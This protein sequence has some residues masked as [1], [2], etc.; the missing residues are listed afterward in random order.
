MFL[1]LSN[2][3]GTTPRCVFS[4]S[5]SLPRHPDLLLDLPRRDAAVCPEAAQTESNA[6]SSARH[7]F[8]PPDPR[9]GFIR[10]SAVERLAGVAAPTQKQRRGLRHRCRPLVPAHLPPNKPS[11]RGRCRQNTK[12]ING[13][14]PKERGFNLS[15]AQGH[16]LKRSPT[17]CDKRD[18]RRRF[19]APRPTE[20]DK[21]QG[22][23]GCSQLRTETQSLFRSLLHV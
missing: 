14:S 6:H 15:R 7:W 22:P 3:P 1:R 12:V 17:T 10:R 16:F 19:L 13:A 11:G 8:L 9:D 23:R 5:L 4:P 21:C 2:H 18:P 20:P